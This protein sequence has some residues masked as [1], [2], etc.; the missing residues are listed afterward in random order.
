[1]GLKVYAKISGANLMLIYN[2]LTLQHSNPSVYEG[3]WLIEES[4]LSE[5]GN[6][7]MIY[8]QSMIM[9]GS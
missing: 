2:N 8:Y 1:M 9:A 5:F 6:A 4:S 7:I 3:K